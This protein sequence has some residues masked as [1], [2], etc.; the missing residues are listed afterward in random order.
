MDYKRIYNELISNAKNRAL[1]A[2][3]YTETHHILPRS[4][5]GKDNPANLVELTYREHILAH[6][7][8][9]RLHPK[10]KE[11]AY[12]FHMM[13]R[14]NRYSEQIN[15]RYSLS[16]LEEAKDAII[17]AR[18]GTKHSN[19]TRDKIKQTW[20]RK[21]ENGYVGPNTNK[22]TSDETK[23]KMSD[24]KKGKPRSQETKDKIS[25]T[26]RKQIA[27]NGHHRTGKKHSTETREKLRIARANREER[28]RGVKKS[29]FINGKM[30]QYY[31]DMPDYIKDMVGDD[32][33]GN[34]TECTNSTIEEVDNIT[35]E[36]FEDTASADYEGTV[37]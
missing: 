16:Q 6:R 29:I 17:R 20:Q 3:T 18:T 28:K 4:L 25:E 27:E 21:V 7:L 22:T 11:L 14:G 1:S 31:G 32:S 23:Q 10:S 8:L 13:V 12:A 24:A 33:V 26:K 35:F 2:D 37:I 34:P 15:H 36:P 19:E 30:Y 5:G 9:Y